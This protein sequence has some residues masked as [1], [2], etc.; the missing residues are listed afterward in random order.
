MYSASS[1]ETVADVLFKLVFAVGTFQY[2]VQT[3]GAVGRAVGQVGRTGEG[4]GPNR[5]PS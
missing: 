2:L 3:H 1:F 4:H 5:F